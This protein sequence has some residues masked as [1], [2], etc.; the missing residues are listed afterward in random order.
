VAEPYPF[1]EI[2]AK[3]QPR[4]E[5]DE[6]WAAPRVPAREKRYVLE[7]YPYPS[8]D[9][10]VGHV[11]NYT[12]GDAIGRFWKMRGYDVLH[13]FGFDAFGLPAENAAITR[14]IHPKE[15]TYANIDAF[16]ATCKRL[17]FAYDWSR[18][19]ASSDP[20]QFRWNQWI[21]LR[22]FERGLA[23]RGTAKVNW[24]PKC[25]TVLAN[26]QISSGFCWR[27]TDTVPEVRDLEQWFYKITEY[28]DRLLEDMD[29][30]EWSDAVLTQQRNWIGRS[31]GA[32]VTFTIAETGDEIPIFTTRPDTLYGVTFFVFAAEHPIAQQ[33]AERAGKADEYRTFVDDVRRSTEIERLATQRDRRAFDLQARAVNPLNGEEVPVFA[34]DYV[35]ME[36]GT[37]AIM[38]VPAHDQRDFEFAQQLGLPIRVVVEDPDGQ[39]T[40]T[41]HEGE[42]VMV[43]SGPFTGTHTSVGRPAIIAHIEEQGIGKAEVQYR[44]RDWLISRQRYWGTPFPVVYCETDGIVSLSDDDLPVELPEDA[45]YRPTGEPVSPLANATDWVKTECPRCGGEARRETDTMDGF[46]DSSWYFLRFC[47]PHNDARIADRELSDAWMPVDQY[48]GGI[49]HA[50]MHLIYA[51]FITKF[52]YDIGEVG[53]TEPFRRLM[54]HGMITLTGEAMSKSSGH[55]VEPREVIDRYGVDALRVYILF[56]GPPTDPFDWPAEGA[57]AVVGAHRFCERVWRLVTSNEDALRAAGAP[58]GSS[59]LRK[60]VHRSLVAIT[61]RYDRFAFNTVISELMTLQRTLTSAAGSAPPEELREGVGVLL[62]TLAPIA[63]YLTEELWER[64][65]GEGSVHDRAW[66]EP[67]AVLATAERVTMVVQVDSKVRDRIEVPADISEEDAIAAGRASEKVQSALRGAEP[68]R[69]VARPP[70]LVN[71]VTR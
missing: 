49:E 68:A 58:T 54:N 8:G 34:S 50:V 39:P 55:Y 60:S 19:F 52:L 6:A 29:Q 15:W 31:E 18:S 9:M 44:M 66:P 48:T 33:L 11:E 3:W 24:C 61:D 65:G 4:W 27:H 28:A 67:D 59:D 64:I 35:L 14:G 30:L 46:M 12:I 71:F 20:E 21:F 17:A 62:H 10:H 36:Y 41:A 38:A 5:R 56:I 25:Q 13:P 69:V 16:R 40:D 22:L 63:P 23:Y 7:M 53:V 57:D 43:D 42:G 51:R 32:R 70:R 37:G 2:E 45:D 47:D 26:E 1:G